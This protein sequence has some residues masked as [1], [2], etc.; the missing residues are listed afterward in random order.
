MGIRWQVPVNERATELRSS[1]I[2]PHASSA[3]HPALGPPST[4]G[5]TVQ[6]HEGEQPPEVRRIQPHAPSIAPSHWGTCT[7]NMNFDGD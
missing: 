2:Q 4:T 7:L 6:G 1:I 5:G 3:A